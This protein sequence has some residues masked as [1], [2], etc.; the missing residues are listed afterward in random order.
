MVTKRK[1]NGSTRGIK[2]EIDN[3]GQ[4]EYV[5]RFSFQLVHSYFTLLY[6]FHSKEANYKY[7]NT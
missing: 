4:L 5:R 6:L 2:S 1:T 7:A 3:S